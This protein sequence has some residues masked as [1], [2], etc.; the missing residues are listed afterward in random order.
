MLQKAFSAPQ[1]QPIPNTACSNPSG[2]G[3]SRRL[4]FTKWVSGTGIFSLRPPRASPSSTIRLLCPANGNFIY[5]S[6]VDSSLPTVPPVRK[7]PKRLPFRAMD[8]ISM[9][10]S[11]D[12]EQ[13]AARRAEWQAVAG[14]SLIE[15]IDQEGGF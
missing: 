14:N 10:C 12:D 2:N 1:K 6:R 3:A 5:T 4:P 13:L 9:A 15:R 7:F 8:P 11:L